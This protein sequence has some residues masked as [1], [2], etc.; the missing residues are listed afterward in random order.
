MEYNV[1]AKRNHLVRL[2]DRGFSVTGDTLLDLDIY[3]W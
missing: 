1:V 2:R 3:F